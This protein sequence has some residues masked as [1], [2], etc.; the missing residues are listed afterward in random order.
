MR[1]KQLWN[2]MQEFRTSLQPF[3]SKAVMLGSTLIEIAVDRRRPIK[4]GA[5]RNRYKLDKRESTTRNRPQLD[6]G[7]FDYSK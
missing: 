5:T 6:R 1:R 3:K 7:E 2:K 4:M